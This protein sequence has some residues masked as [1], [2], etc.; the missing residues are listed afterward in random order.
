MHLNM[1]NGLKSSTS[2]N[3]QINWLCLLITVWLLNGR[4]WYIWPVQCSQLPLNLNFLVKLYYKNL[5]YKSN[6]CFCTNIAAGCTRMA[7]N[8]WCGAVNVVAFA[9]CLCIRVFIW[10]IFLLQVTAK[11]A[12]M[13]I[14]IQYNV[15]QSLETGTA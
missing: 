12:I 10:F 9:I 8:I 4:N 2:H 7:G 3:E 15:T 14:T 5:L 13:F 6:L 11:F 1:L